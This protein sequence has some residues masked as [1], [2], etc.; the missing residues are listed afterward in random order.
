MNVVATIA[1]SSAICVAT[2]CAIRDWRSGEIPNWLTL[3]PLLVAPLAY[4]VAIGPEHAARSFAAACLNAVVPYFLF[5]RGGMGGGDVKIFTALGA[6]T[7]FEP[8]L[9]L[10]IQLAA[11]F[12]ATLFAFGVLAWRGRLLRTLASMVGQMTRLLPRAGHRSPLSDDLAAPIRM[13]VPILVATGICLG[14][15]LLLAWGQL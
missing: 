15:R 7:G 11:L 2:V 8:L 1:S 4:G 13:G 9:G 12:V 3:P 10:E 5:R 14:P 6:I